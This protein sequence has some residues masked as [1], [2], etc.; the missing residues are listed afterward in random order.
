[1][2]IL[3]KLFGEHLQEAIKKM[4]RKETYGLRYLPSA[5]GFVRGSNPLLNAKKHEGSEF[6]Y[7]TDFKD[8]Y[9]SVDLHRLAILL[10]YIEYYDYY[11]V[12]YSLRTFS[13]NELA[14]YEISC[15]PTF[16]QME[17]FVQIAF[18]GLYGKGL[19]IGGPLSP[20]LLNLYC[21]VFVDSPLRFYFFKREDV[22]DPHRSI[23][24]TRFADDLTFSS[25]EF[26]G[27]NMRKDIR[28]IINNAG[29][30][31]N[32]KKTF[33]YKRSMGT[34][35]ITKLGIRT[36]HEVVEK[37]EEAREK[38]KVGILTFSQKKRRCINGILQS[39]LKPVPQK[40]GASTKVMGYQNDSPEIVS[41]M[42]AEFLYYFKNVEKPT[43][44]NKKTFALCK[45]F[46][47]IATPYL[48]KV[49]KVREE[50]RK[51]KNRNP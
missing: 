12:D 41:G 1:M 22:R 14:Q 2:R 35:F 46:E 38:D 37:E 18:G 48:R 51:Q 50:K 29:F 31:I 10:T 23:I 33:I 24:F 47:R 8:A 40:E 28:R 19:A 36:E 4:G 49:Q 25:K 13:Q 9:P 32:L 3:H 5:T 11:G 42:I 30:E 43:E 20:Y 27:A 7:I 15:D 34:V 39:F 6:F 16:Q 44:S 26:I 17:G 45:E 21:E